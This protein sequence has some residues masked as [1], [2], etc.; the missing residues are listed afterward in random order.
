M[1]RETLCLSSAETTSSGAASTVYRVKCVSS[2]F[3]RRIWLSALRVKT[4]STRSAESTR[5]QQ[6]SLSAKIAWN[7]ICASRSWLIALWSTLLRT[8]PSIAIAVLNYWKEETTVGYAKSLSVNSPSLNWLGVINAVAGFT[9]PATKHSNP[10]S[11][12][13]LSQMSNITALSAETF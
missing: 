4:T 8:V 1:R 5:T 6:P 7:A 9:S 10:T 11:S 12:T 2:T 3:K 13:L